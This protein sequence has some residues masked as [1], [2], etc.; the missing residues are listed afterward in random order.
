MPS[1]RGFML[2]A[3]PHCKRKT[4]EHA[5]LSGNSFGARYRSD[6][7]AAEPMGFDDRIVARCSGCGQYYLIHETRTGWIDAARAPCPSIEKVSDFQ[8]L[9]RAMQ[10][11]KAE[12][13]L[14][15]ETERALRLRMLWT[16]NTPHVRVDSLAAD[17]NR[18]ALLDMDGTKG[19][20]KVELLRELGEF[21]AA[22][23]AVDSVPEDDGWFTALPQSAKRLRT[24]ARRPSGSTLGNRAGIV[25]R[26]NPIPLP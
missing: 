13:K 11:F 21:E 10:Q 25:F 16:S 17:A 23:E 15:C 12:G 24:S 22:A 3:C 9:Q 19:Y 26:N 18:R 2:H 8:S 14:D 4:C 7:L 5:Q 1:F 6:M 20:L